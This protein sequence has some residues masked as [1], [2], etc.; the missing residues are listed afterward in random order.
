MAVSDKTVRG[1]YEIP[2]AQ[3]ALQHYAPWFELLRA[4]EALVQGGKHLLRALRAWRK[5]EGV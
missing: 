2:A 4:G 5:R 3:V 1:A